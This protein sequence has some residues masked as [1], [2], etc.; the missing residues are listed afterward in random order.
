MELSSMYKYKASYKRLPKLII[1]A[2][3]TKE[4]GQKAAIEYS[5]L[6]ET[7]DEFSIDIELLSAPVESFPTTKDLSDFFNEVP[8]YPTEPIEDDEVTIPDATPTIW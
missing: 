6:G 2:K 3:N 5:K 4:A 8:V 7:V 1:L